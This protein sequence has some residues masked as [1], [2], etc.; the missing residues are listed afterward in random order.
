MFLN[1]AA[2]GPNKDLLSWVC[3]KDPSKVFQRDQVIAW[4]TGGT[5][6][7]NV[8]IT[9]EYPDY[10]L[11]DANARGVDN[12]VTD[13]G[14]AAS[15]LFVGLLR[16]T[17]GSALKG[18]YSKAGPNGEDLAAVRFEKLAFTLGPIVTKM[19]SVEVIDFLESLG[20]SDVNVIEAWRPAWMPFQHH[21]V[22]ILGNS[23]QGTVSEVLR[24]LAVTILCA[25]NYLHYRPTED[26]MKV[27]EALGEGWLETHPQKNK[28]RARVL[29][30][31]KELLEAWDQSHPSE[32]VVAVAEEETKKDT[33]GE[34]RM[35]WFIQQ[36]NFAPHR[37]V[38]DAGCGSGR[39]AQRVIAE[40]AP[41]SV[42]AFDVNQRACHMASRYCKTASVFFSS[43]IYSDRRLYGQD[44]F[45]LQEVIEHL[46]PGQLDRMID[47]VFNRYRPG[48]V[49]V[50]TP[51]RAMNKAFGLPEGTLRHHDHKFEMD[52]SEALAFA[53]RILSAHN[54]DFTLHRI[55]KGLPADHDP[56]LVDPADA[57]GTI[58][59]VFRRR[60]GVA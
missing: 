17:F 9:A 6:T 28:I 45:C 53:F 5:D 49:L 47:I 3:Q 31:R 59:I 10:A 20:F 33:L 27:L 21:V 8:T 51:N 32:V 56:A 16:S 35:A 37:S 41:P 60:D 18:K 40:I 50:S 55:G 23:L 54:Y 14:Y 48:T 58:G 25:D 44:V 36:I 2:F 46:L 52:W 7:F 24:R 19:D 38:V 34:A 1:L 22:T 39:L 11:W 57:F 13:R 30:Y 43:L 29:G 12:Y 26:H 15:S 4:F 42:I